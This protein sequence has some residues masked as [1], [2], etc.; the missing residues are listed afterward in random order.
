MI[1]LFLKCEWL[2]DKLLPLFV[3][4]VIQDSAHNLL[5]CIKGWRFVSIF[6]RWLVLTILELRTFVLLHGRF[7]PEVLPCF[8]QTIPG[9]RTT[10]LSHL[11]FAFESQ[12]RHAWRPTGWTSAILFV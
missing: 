3:L 2:S 5:D 9:W 7:F 4:L 1:E 6:R 12:R 11:R 8:A 10:T